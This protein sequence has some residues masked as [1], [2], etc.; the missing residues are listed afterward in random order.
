MDILVKLD[1]ENAGLCCLL[2]LELVLFQVFS[3]LRY[4]LVVFGQQHWLFVLLF[5]GYG[6]F[7]L[8]FKEM[9]LIMLKQIISFG[10]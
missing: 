8:L 9:D 10:E 6:I 1:N 2:Q 3:C 7:P 4:A 5:T